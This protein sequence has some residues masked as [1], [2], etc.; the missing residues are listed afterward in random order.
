MAGEQLPE[1]LVAAEAHALTEEERARV[2]AMTEEEF[3]AWLRGDNVS[4]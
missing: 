2:D 3:R 4:A 1:W